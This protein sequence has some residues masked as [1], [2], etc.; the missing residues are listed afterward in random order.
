[1]GLA[2]LLNRAATSPN[3]APASHSPGW[4]GPTQF[5]AGPEQRWPPSSI[6]PPPSESDA[7]S[8]PAF[9][10]GCAYVCGTVGML[11]RNVYR[12]TDL[13][14][15]QPPVIVQPDPNQT[16]M[17][18]WTGMAESLT[19]YG[20]A[21]CIIVDRDRN[22]WPTILKP[23]HPTLAAVR[24]T[25]NPMAP[26]IAAWYV[27]GQLYDPNDIWHVKSHLG[28]AGWPLGRGLIDTASDPI[29]MS[30]AM[31]SY[32]A[33]YFNSGGMPTGV[34][35]VHR[36]EVTQAQA[37]TAKSQWITKYAGTPSI[38]VLNELTDFTPVAFKPVDSQM[39]ESR[40][41]EL[42][43]VALLW[44]IPPSKL[45][46]TV[47]GGTYKN[48]EG[49]EIQARNDAVAPW[50]A[51][52]A[53]AASIELIPRGQ[54]VL[55]DLSALLRTDTL[56]LYQ[57]YNFALGGPGPTS[58]WMLID[59]IRAKEN[60]DPMPIVADEIDAEIKA[61]GVKA[62]P[63]MPGEPAPAKPVQPPAPAPVMPPIGQAPTDANRMPMQNPPITAAANGQGG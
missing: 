12:D 52:L 32:A 27:A 3:Q 14:D 39:I 13:V 61:A 57:A 22:G 58:Q 48:A 8:V 31:Q 53:E 62:A 50:T 60:L 5:M 24:F 6:L 45:G 42:I 47:G 40:A 11:P 17:A 20:N 7:L 33:A 26:T 29:A 38:A 23:I 37:D 21:I 16:P 54:N 55:W 4:M 49:E 63:V 36:P 9:W 51:L 1:M 46:A 44:G 10:R 56:S 30:L 35:K 59:E 15:P 34:L 2:R 18:F 25:G 19:L 28:R 41:H 43:D